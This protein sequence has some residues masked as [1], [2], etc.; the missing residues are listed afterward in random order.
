MEVEHP[1]ESGDAVDHEDAAMD[2]TNDAADNAENK[3]EPEDGRPAQPSG[4]TVNEMRRRRRRR[5]KR[6]SR[7]KQEK[8][9]ENISI[10]LTNC[11][12]YSS[13]E[14]SIKKDIIEKKVPDVLLINETLLT[15]ERK[16]KSKDYI[17]FVKNREQ[18]ETKGG[19]GGGGGVATLVANHLRQNTVK[20]GEGSEGDEYLITRLNHVRPALN[21][22]NIYGENESRAGPT[23]VLESWLRLKRD[24]D[25]INGRGEMTLCMGDMNRAIGA[26]EYGV[27]GNKEQISAGGELIREH[28][29]KTGE[30]VLLNNLSLT[31]GGPYTWVQP[32]KEEVKSCLDLALASANLAPFVRNV[33]IDKDRKFTPRRVIRKPGGIKTIFTD[34]YSVEVRIEGLPRSEK[35]YE[36]ETNWNLQKPGGWESYSRLTKE[37][38]E[39]IKVV[40]ENKGLDVNETM[41]KVETIETKIKFKAFGKTKAKTVKKLASKGSLSHEELLESQSQ[42]VEEAINKVETEG[43]GRVGNIY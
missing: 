6:R 12:G 38:A 34:H 10:I 24:L 30:F 11:K 43:K 41:R 22:I 23:K 14:E 37:A 2:T 29:L 21:I 15:G 36:K 3:D 26:G 28:M 40:A 7:K 32:G 25:E 16:I 33:V 31:E 13:K 39:E 27:K 18:K 9:T 17:S 5:R 4:Q 20:T 8:E 42:R 35:V 1:A 19:V